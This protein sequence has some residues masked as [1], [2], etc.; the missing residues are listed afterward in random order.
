MRDTE[1]ISVHPTITL[2]DNV[3]TFRKFLC[4]WVTITIVDA[5]VSGSWWR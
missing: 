2:N 3:E 4:T 1:E 5:V